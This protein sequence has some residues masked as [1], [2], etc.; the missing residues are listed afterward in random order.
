MEGWSPANKDIYVGYLFMIYYLFSAS[1]FDGIPPLTP[2]ILRYG[3][4]NPN[5]S[6]K[7]LSA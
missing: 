1:E 2:K 6:L 7:Y 4:L 5:S 3:R